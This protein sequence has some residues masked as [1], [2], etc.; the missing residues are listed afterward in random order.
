MLRPHS[1][2][3]RL[4]GV[5]LLGL[6]GACAQQAGYYDPPHESTT[7]DARQRAQ[8]GSGAIAPSQLQLGFGGQDTRQAPASAA[9]PAAADAAL[10]VPVSPD[11]AAPATTGRTGLP[12]ALADTRTY[13][14]TVA[15][16]D[17]SACL[18]RRLVLTLAPDG[19]WRARSTPLQ[20]N[21]PVDTAMGC[22]F[23]TQS[24][25]PRIVLLAGEHPYASLELAQS[26]VFKVLRL[27]DQAPLLE[28]RLTRQ[29]DLDPIAE[30]A[31]RPAQACP[32]Q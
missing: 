11:P 8:G 23:P 30:L 18:A 13:L 6:L 3:S 20:G 14:G 4:L 27:N 16:T 9:A 22:W 24:A 12:Q 25:P 17:A 7:S 29:A 28:S 31:S 15:C 10:P 2:S 19:Q 21:A 5:G 32:A 1:L 26:N